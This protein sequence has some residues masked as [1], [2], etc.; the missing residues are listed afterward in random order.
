MA[1]TTLVRP[2]PALQRGFD[3]AE[4]DRLIVGGDSSAMTINGTLGATA[5]FLFV[6][7][8]SAAVGWTRVSLGWGLVA[9]LI[10]AGLGIYTSFRPQRAQFTGLAYAVLE[11]LAVGAISKMY[12]D[13]Y[14]GIVVQAVGLTV[15]VLV[16]LLLVYR[17]GVIK[18]TQNFRL[19][20]AGATMGVALFYLASFGA[21]M[22]GIELPLIHS[23]GTFGILFSLAVVCLAAASLVVD[24][25]FV[26]RGAQ[27]G[28]PKYM[29]WYGAFGLM[30]SLVW[31]YLELLRLL[32]KLQS[33]D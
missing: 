32:S 17:T 28:L 29:E 18:V 21:S 22:F 4:Q 33:R 31:L 16:A 19:A 8:G 15:G 30:V 2:N 3:Q 26:E 20:V 12:N 14:D 27:E 9:M 1:N 6:L 11:G 23:N 24:F 7:L 10:A 13:Q 25:D 5:V